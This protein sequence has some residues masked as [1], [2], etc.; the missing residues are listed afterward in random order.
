MY[1]V[2]H[3]MCTFI[4]CTYVIDLV[5][6][7]SEKDILLDIIQKAESNHKL[8]KIRF[9]T[10]LCTGLPKTGKTSFCNLIMDG[11]SASSPA[12]NF[13]TTFI[14]KSM[15]GSSAK[16]TKWKVIDL[17]E[18][19]KLI[20]ALSSK[21]SGSLHETWDVLFLLDICVP[22]SAL[23]LLPDSIITFVTYKMLGENFELNDPCEFIKNKKRYSNFLKEF[24]SSICCEKKIKKS[25]FSELKINNKNRRKFYIAFIGTLD[26]S[27]FE[28]S[29]DKEAEIVNESLH[30]IKEHINCPISDFPLPIWY[31]E[32]NNQYLHLVNVTS[33]KEKH[34]EKVKSGL[35]DI[36]AKTSIYKVPESWML[37]HLK[38]KKFCISNKTSVIEYTIAYE[39]L[40]R[41]NTNSNEDE[42]KLAL[43]FFH[44]VGALLYFHSI[45]GMEN[46]V[47]MDFRWLI[48]NLKY[49]YDTKDSTFQYDY[50]ARLVLKYEGELMASMIDEMKFEKLGKVNSEDFLNLL[51]NLRIFAP[52]SQGNYFIPSILDSHEGYNV[53][54][55]YGELK[56]SKPLLITLSSGSLHRSIF[57]YLAAHMTDNLLPNWSKPKYDE[58]NKRQHTFK[59]LVTF[60]V[61]INSYICHVS[62][63]DKTFFIEIRLYSKS[64]SDCPT[65]LHLIVFKFIE[66]SLK[67]V[68]KDN[69]HLPSNY[70]KYGFL[71]CKCEC[72]LKPH[73]MVIK[74]ESNHKIAFCSKT[75]EVEVL[76]E[77]YTVWFNKVCYKCMYYSYKFIVK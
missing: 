9:S 47:I 23:C 55:Y 29:Y 14:K 51:E 21:K 77:N 74:D 11:S 19:N 71:C 64:K 17:E 16:E 8:I 54:S 12:G 60:C 56:S 63:L 61:T 7:K 1:I 2:C 31:M 3:C 65:D 68:L 30:I 69:L 34:F 44:S 49:L 13:H 15:D 72:K 42:L 45:K 10:V 66:K 53:F 38:I 25:E 52:V 36:V 76:D 40:W 20:D 58:S 41:N 26:G 39:N 62:I 70:Y 18:L 22:T 50:N 73:L 32:D 67:I 27:S 75:D 35:E 24:L 46:F 48:D 6:P 57:C 5:G 43:R 28:E 37:F 33:R 59:D 4:L